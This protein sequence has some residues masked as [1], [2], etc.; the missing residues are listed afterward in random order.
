MHKPPRKAGAGGLDKG[1]IDQLGGVIS[2][3]ISSADPDRNVASL[4]GTSAQPWQPVGGA[5]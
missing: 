4:A 3:F 5:R 1:G 2:L